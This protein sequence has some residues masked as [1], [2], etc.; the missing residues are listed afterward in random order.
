MMNYIFHRSSGSSREESVGK[1]PIYLRQSSAAFKVCGKQFTIR[2]RPWND[3]VDAQQLCR[4][5][6]HTNARVSS[7]DI[8]HCNGGQGVY[9][10]ISLISQN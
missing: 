8:I 4:P 2:K 5:G 7:P 3:S 9:Q 10:I 1:E 6:N